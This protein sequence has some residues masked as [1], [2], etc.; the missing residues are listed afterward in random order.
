MP[1]AHIRFERVTELRPKSG[2]LVEDV[3]AAGGTCLDVMILLFIR[4]F[5]GRCLIDLLKSSICHE[6]LSQ[7]V[8]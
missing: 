5:V 8:N 1:D 7:Q 3:S 6:C 4:F 2:E